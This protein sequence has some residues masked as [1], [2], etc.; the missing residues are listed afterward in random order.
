MF[1]NIYHSQ[2]IM[3]KFASSCSYYKQLNCK[4]LLN[5]SSVDIIWFSLILSDYN[6]RAILIINFGQVFNRGTFRTFKIVHL[7]TVNF[8]NKK[9]HLSCLARFSIRFCLLQHLC[10]VGIFDSRFRIK[11]FTTLASEAALHK[12]S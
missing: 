3:Q 6:I 9:L 10:L 11:R 7:K 4:N 8:L 12:C 5:T 1:R 2:K